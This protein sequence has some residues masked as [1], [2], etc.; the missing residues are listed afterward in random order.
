M[1]I[2]QSLDPLFPFFQQDHQL[3]DWE[4]LALLLLR[5]LPALLEIRSGWY[6]G[7]IW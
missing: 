6:T 1:F 2:Y 5:H 3:N 7:A 4:Q